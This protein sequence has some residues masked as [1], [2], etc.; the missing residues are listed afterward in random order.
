MYKYKLTYHMKNGEELDFVVTANGLS[1]EVLE[2]VQ[3]DIMN[4]PKFFVA[5]RICIV[6]KDEISHVSCEIIESEGV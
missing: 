4:S 3:Q 5:H 1:E 2:H 6:H